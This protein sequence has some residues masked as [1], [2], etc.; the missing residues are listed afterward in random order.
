MSLTRSF[1]K[2]LRAVRHPKIAYRWFRR[3]FVVGFILP[4]SLRRALGVV[5]PPYVGRSTMRSLYVVTYGRSGSTLLTGYLSLL[6]GIRLRGENYL[7]PLPL[8]D[9]QSRLKD[10][11]SL[12]YSNRESPSSPWYGSQLFSVAR[13][14]RDQERLMLNQLYPRQPIPKTIGFKEIRWWYRVAP[15]QFPEVMTW[16]TNIRAPGAVIFLTRDLDRVMAGAWWARQ[17]PEERAHSRAGLEAFEERAKS[18]AHD[19][20]ERSVWVT[21]EEFT[22]SP[23]AAQRVCDLLGVPFSHKTWQKA[24]NTRYS[25]RS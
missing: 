7:F 22:S 14:R 10:A 21:Y 23:S 15:E 19:H 6:P 2:M 20:P 16:L 1:R 17:S 8:F 5:L 3:N 11:A 25:Y 12:S 9:A 18:Y 4:Y 13:W 24:L